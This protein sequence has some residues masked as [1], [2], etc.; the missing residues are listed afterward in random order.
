MK[1]H[2]MLFQ[3]EAKSSYREEIVHELLSNTE[4]DIDSN[5]DRI[6]AWIEQWSK[7]NQKL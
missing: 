2:L 1:I 3:D 4:Q 6:C 7:D 5:V